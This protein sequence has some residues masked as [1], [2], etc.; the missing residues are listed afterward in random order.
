M[1]VRPN[2]PALAADVDPALLERVIVDGDLSRL[3]PAHRVAYYLMKCR[4]ARLDPQAQPFQY[5]TLQGKLTLYATKACTQQ[6]AAIHA[7]STHVTEQRT[8]GDLRLVTVR[9]RA[10]D[11]R[12][13]DELGA[14]GIKGLA[15]EALANA[16]MKALTKAKRRAVLAI[17][18]LGDLDESEVD[19]VPHA[20]RANVDIATGVVRGTPDDMDA[21]RARAAAEGRD[22]TDEPPMDGPPPGAEAQDL[23]EQIAA[24]A[25]PLSEEQ[26]ASVAKGVRAAGDDVARLRAG[27]AFV[28]TLVAAAKAPDPQDEPP[29][30]ADNA[31]GAP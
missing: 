11:G 3:T 31:G 24:L 2:L 6:L 15:G 12:E 13:T 23:R 18:G 28:R 5:I 20:R 30:D 14:V 9:A 22:V 19:S 10:G 25:E 8:E 21:A 29:F 1:S 27:L 26:R 4:A 16:Y 17:C 7:V